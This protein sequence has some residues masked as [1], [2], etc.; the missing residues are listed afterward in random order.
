MLVARFVLKNI[1]LVENKRDLYMIN[2]EKVGYIT[3]LLLLI[4]LVCASEAYADDQVLEI[5]KKTGHV[6]STTVD[7]VT[8]KYYDIWKNIFCAKNKFTEDD[9]NKLITIEMMSVRTDG[10]YGSFYILYDFN[11]SWFKMTYSDGFAIMLKPGTNEYAYLNISRG[12]FLS[13]TE[14][15][16]ILALYN[17]QGIGLM[18]SIHPLFIKTELEAINIFW[19]NMAKQKLAKFSIKEIKHEIIDDRPYFTKSVEIAG[20]CAHGSL[21]LVTGEFKSINDD[22][23]FIVD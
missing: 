11:I 4:I 2:K 19:V 10:Y 1:L 15:R 5:Y 8:K 23:V 14:V 22:C 13:E 17:Y 21:N 9:Y 6:V 12:V 7:E 20:K 18:P 3:S 16:K